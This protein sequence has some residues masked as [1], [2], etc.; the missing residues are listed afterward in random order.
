MN[1]LFLCSEP[2]FPTNNGVRIPAY[3]FIKCLSKYHN[4]KLLCF[5]SN[6]KNEDEE[7]RLELSKYCNAVEFIERKVVR[8]HIK[9][10][11][12]LFSRKPHFIDNHH[13][14]LMA[15]RIK[16]H[17]E[18]YNLDVIHFDTLPMS[19]FRTIDIGN[20]ATVISPNDSC[21]L[22][23]EN[24]ISWKIQSSF[25]LFVFN[26]VL[27]KKTK[28]FESLSYPKFDYC[29]VV[30][31]VDGNYLKSLNPQIN[32]RVI[33]NAVDTEYFK[34]TCFSPEGKLA[35]FVGSLYG[36]SGT[37]MKIFISKVWR[38]VMELHPDAR[39][40]IAGKSTP[41]L[42]REMQAISHGIVPLGYVDDIRTCYSQTL[43]VV[44]P[45]LKN[46]GIV[47]KALEGMSMGRT[48]VGHTVSF[49][50]IPQC[51]NGFNVMMGDNPVQLVDAFDELF[52]YPNRA[53]EIGKMARQ[54]IEEHYTWE[55]RCG[56]IN[57]L[58]EDAFLNN[59][60]AERGNIE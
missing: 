59:T 35:L 49:S 48:V 54:L 30:S 16:Y 33:A 15:S 40:Y 20:C 23:I 51:K 43:T 37:Y 18:K 60:D 8:K 47:N 56:L 46:C 27:L 55:S 11:R 5:G 9:L 29:H 52:C 57:A 58:Y 10:L 1:I 36:G 28:R 7:C 39:L 6:S 26:R 4:I 24:E 2:P 38:H 45:V 31:Q 14:S 44:N 50:G 42:I 12:F 32:T 3:N 22:A 19:T 53:I 25:L 13:D 21:S 17:I 34:P 41:E